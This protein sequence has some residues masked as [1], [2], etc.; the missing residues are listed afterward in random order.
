MADENQAAAQTALAN[1][2][3]LMMLGEIRGLVR[4]LKD[5]QEAMDGRM[6]RM[7]ARLEGMDDRLRQVEQK[8]ATIGA[9]AGG[10]MGL[11]V[12]LIVEGVKHWLGTRGG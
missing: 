7:E 10:A 8:A 6:G 5:G 1:A 12:A 3:A 2:Q 4:G 11:G 9:G